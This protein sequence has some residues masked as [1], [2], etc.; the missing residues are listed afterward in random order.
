MFRDIEEP[1]QISKHVLLRGVVFVPTC[2]STPLR[3]S[4]QTHSLAAPIPLGAVF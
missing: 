2:F 3:R 4:I 1:T